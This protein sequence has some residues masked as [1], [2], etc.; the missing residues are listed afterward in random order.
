MLRKHESDL[1]AVLLKLGWVGND[2]FDDQTSCCL[3]ERSVATDRDY[4]RI[5]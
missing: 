4:Y 2:V 3:R 1:G 5:I